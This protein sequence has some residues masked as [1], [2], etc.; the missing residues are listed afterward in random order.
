MPRGLVGQWLERP[1]YEVLP[2]PWV[3]QV[4]RDNL[5]PGTFVTVTSSP[6]RGMEATVEL[7]EA[8]TADGYSVVPHL[9]ARAM[10]DEERLLR[11]VERLDHVGVRDVFVVGG[12]NPMWAGPYESGV[13]LLAALRTLGHP[14]TDIGVPAYPEGHPTIDDA[15]LWRALVEKQRD[16]TYVVT[17]MCFS[18]ETIAAWAGTA[19]H[20]GVRLPMR[21]GIPGL[22]QRRRLALMTVRI[23]VGDS[24]RF[25]RKQSMSLA[26]LLRPGGYSPTPL[27]RRLARL[28][29]TPI[30]GLHLYTFNQIERTARWAREHAGALP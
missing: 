11:I 22:V 26:R 2:L 25:L 13:E 6:S 18:A 17:Q 30:V 21:V 24:A 19:R 29:D 7:T 16:A 14:F 4:V 5:E 20:H 27:V 15:T 3:R 9:A 10:D 12:D 28:P 8:L 23:G 1:H